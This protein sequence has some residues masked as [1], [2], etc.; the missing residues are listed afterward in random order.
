MLFRSL[1]SVTVSS[2]NVQ[3]NGASVFVP[4][5]LGE[6]AT[7]SLLVD[8]VGSVTTINLINPGEDYVATPN[9][10]LRVQDIVVSS[11]FGLEFAKDTI[12]YQGNIESPTF[13]AYFDSI[14]SIDPGSINTTADDLFV[15]RVFDYKGVVSENAIILYD[16][17][18]KTEIGSI[19]FISSY[20]NEVFTAG[21][22][23]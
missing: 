14:T 15:L 2:S 22:K 7:F 18:K 21:K 5:I 20:T 8:R 23:I 13:F 11:T 6:G 19:S 10:S 1:P 4:G 17:E 9:V 16:N 12:V 3:A